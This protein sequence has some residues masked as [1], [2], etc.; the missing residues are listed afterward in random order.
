M[1]GY[2]P[3]HIPAGERMVNAMLSSAL[4]LYGITGLIIDDLYIPGKR[5][6]G[7]HFH[8]EPILILFIAFLCAAANMMSVVV[9]HYDK[10]NNEIDYKRFARTSQVA[11][12]TF[13]ILAV[14]LDLFVFH[15][16]TRS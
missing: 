4:L 6:L 3:N 5:R 7:M 16:A 15:K 2:N 14:I 8:G 11:G 9:D 13:F 10:R 12:W 1:P